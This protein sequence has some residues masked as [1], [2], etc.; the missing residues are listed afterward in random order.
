MMID[1]DGKRLWS[2]GVAGS[3]VDLPRILRARIPHCQDVIRASEQEDRD[4]V[5]YWALRPP[6]R[7]LGIDLKVRNRDYRADGK[8]DLALETWSVWEQ[9]KVGWTRDVTKNTDFICWYFLDSGRFHL[10]SFPVLCR[11]FRARY[12]AWLRDYGP[13]WTQMSHDKGRSWTSKHIYVPRRVVEE[14]VVS[15]MNGDVP[16]TTATTQLALLTPSYM[17][18]HP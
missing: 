18:R 3:Q 15:W 14:A 5:D 11:V 17:R 9:G 12:D 8:D 2:D 4:G 13:E 7:R 10:T 6:A 16:R 1:F